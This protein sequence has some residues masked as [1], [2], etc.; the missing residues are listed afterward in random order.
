MLVPIT[1]KEYDVVLDIRYATQN[2]FTGKE[3]Y[4]KPGCYLHP[5]AA[6]ALKKAV[7]LAKEQGYK[8]K[9]FDAFRP[10]E[11]QQELWNNN[12]DP[13]FI[14]NPETG[15]IPHCR[16]V[17]VDIN[18]ID[19]DGNE[20]NMGTGFDEFNEK[21]HLGRLDISKDEQRNRYILLGI[22]TTAGW[23]F[24]SKE[25]WHFQ[26]FKPREYKAFTDKEA[27]TGMV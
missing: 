12:P 26:L 21:S 8:I 25:W 3:I 10:L 11:V 2:N 17:A 4:K 18:L 20:L 14:S 16:G 22:M 23:D 9:I 1:E 15:S 13:N 5:D 7:K 19:K 27:G 24:Y 6:A